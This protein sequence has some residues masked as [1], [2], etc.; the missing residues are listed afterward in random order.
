MA[1]PDD[2][3]IWCGGTLALHARSS[4]VGVLVAAT[5]EVRSL[6]ARR[7]AEILGVDLT[8]TDGLTVANCV[9]EIEKRLPDIV[10]C[11]RMDDMHTDH[12]R[13][14]ECVLSAVIQTH[15]SSGY[16]SKLYSC[17]T[18]NSLTLNGNVPGQRIIDVSET[19]DKKMEALSEHKSQ[20]L[21]HFI[22][23]SQRLAKFW[24]AR[25]GCKWG[26]AFDPIPILGKLPPAISL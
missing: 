6:E 17:D 18:Y 11:H 3:E 19:F 9:V 26:E 7:A 1:H 16:P 2:A 5:E 4:S 13:A 12:R 21:A 14:A 25:I 15:I 10:I 24:G 8:V 20:P 23:M 22:D